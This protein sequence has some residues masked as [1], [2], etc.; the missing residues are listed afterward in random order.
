[1]IV[2]GLWHWKVVAEMPLGKFELLLQLLHVDAQAQ[3][4]FRCA[5]GPHRFL[6]VV[7]DSTRRQAACID[8]LLMVKVLRTTVLMR[9]PAQS[10]PAR[11]ARVFLM[12]APRSVNHSRA[13]NSSAVKPMSVIPGQSVR[14]K[15][16][17]NVANINNFS[18]IF[19]LI[20]KI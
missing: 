5:H 16:Q 4:W 14:L 3:S 11:S 12:F 19:V 13:S 10:S 2:Q 8:G 6:T 20:S 17:Q 9:W 15:S 1:M 18:D 7:Q